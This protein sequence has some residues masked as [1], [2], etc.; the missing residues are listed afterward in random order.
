M[1]SVL[2]GHPVCYLAIPPGTLPGP[3][4]ILGGFPHRCVCL[5]VLTV[6][7]EK[8]VRGPFPPSPPARSSLS[9]ASGSSEGTNTSGVLA[10]QTGARGMFQILGGAQSPTRDF[11]QLEK[12]VTTEEAPTG[13]SPWTAGSSRRWVVGPGLEVPGPRVAPCSWPGVPRC[14]PLT[15]SLDLRR[16]FP[17]VLTVSPAA[18]KA[19][20][21]A[22]MSET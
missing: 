21:L 6:R 15:G 3:A 10:L 9:R 8:D 5:S 20:I 14:C 16:T 22:S 1:S 2:T 13:H 11:L 4:F 19:A 17:E 12:Q 7:P 18:R